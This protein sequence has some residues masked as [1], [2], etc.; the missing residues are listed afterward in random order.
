VTQEP[1]IF[2]DMDGVL[3]GHDYDELTESC[4]VDPDCVRW[5]NTILVAVPGAKIVVSSAWR[6]MVHNGAMTLR[7]FEYLLRTHGV[8][9]VDRVTGLTCLDEELEPRGQQIRHWLNEHGGNRPYV[10]LDDGG[11]KDGQWYDL[12]INAASLRVVW[13]KGNVGLTDWDAHRA[14]EI[15]KGGPR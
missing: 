1:V 9:C 4:T 2:L 11:D 14:I 7:G 10:V 8:A 12:G 15:L 13:T 3:N 5:F 6:Y